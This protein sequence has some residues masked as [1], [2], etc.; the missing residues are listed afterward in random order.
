MNKTDPR[1]ELRI[2]SQSL[3]QTRHTN[4]YQ[5]DAS[6]IEDRSHLL[7]TGHFKAIGF[8][9]QN[10]SGRVTN[11]ALLV[12]VLAADLSER[13]FKGWQ[14]F[15]KP[16]IVAE[17][18]VP[19]LDVALLYLLEPAGFF[20]ADGLQMEIPQKVTKFGDISLDFTRCINDWRVYSTASNCAN[21]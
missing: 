3:L 2:A 13:W 6:R 16:I 7:K 9:H 5:A 10:E 15:G 18:R 8:I 4:Q 12:R 1:V 17:K 21:C 14:L 19:V 11:G 20:A